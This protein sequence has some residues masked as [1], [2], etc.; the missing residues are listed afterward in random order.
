MLHLQWMTTTFVDT[1]GEDTAW[2]TV[3]FVYPRPS[4]G[5]WIGVFSPSNFKYV[6][7]KPLCPSIFTSSEY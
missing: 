3:G 5:D 2:V 7:T 1:Q 4:D 6:Y